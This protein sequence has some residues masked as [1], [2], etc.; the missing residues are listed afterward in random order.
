M[1]KKFYQQIDSLKRGFE[2]EMSKRLSSPS[3]SPNKDRHNKSINNSRS[4]FISNSLYK[5]SD[6]RSTRLNETSP[7][8]Q[9]VQTETSASRHSYTAKK[10]SPVHVKTP[11]TRATTPNTKPFTPSFIS[12]ML[13]GQYEELEFPKKLPEKP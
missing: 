13:K 8:P 12:R 9:R 11:I 4:G 6:F 1:E 2:T 3:Q 7:S 10:S 5:S